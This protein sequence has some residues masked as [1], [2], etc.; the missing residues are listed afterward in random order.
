MICSDWVHFSHHEKDNLPGMRPSGQASPEEIHIRGADTK[1]EGSEQKWGSGGSSPEK[2]L[3]PHPSDRWKVPLFVKESP[4]K[5]AV[6]L[7]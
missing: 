2:F 3:R 7:D 1:C 5:E 4:L 6:E